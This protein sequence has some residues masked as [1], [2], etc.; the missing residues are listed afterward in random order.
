MR[1]LVYTKYK[2]DKT[3]RKNLSTIVENK[4]QGIKKLEEYNKYGLVGE[5][6][7]LSKLLKGCET[8]DDKICRVLCEI[9]VDDSSYRRSVKHFS[10]E[11]DGD[12]KHNHKYCDNI[13]T[14]IFKCNLIREETTWEDGSDCYGSI[15][16]YCL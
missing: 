4:E 12:W 11:V 3:D 8:I 2:N 14:K 9:G 13:I 15:H 7:P 6:V 10:V 1:Y 5:L 16:T